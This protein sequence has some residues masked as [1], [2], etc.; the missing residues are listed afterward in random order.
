MLSFVFTSFF[1]FFPLSCATK[2]FSFSL[3]LPI[4]R[5]RFFF[6]FICCLVLYYLRF[7]WC[8]FFRSHLLLFFQFSPFLCLVFFSSFSSS[9]FLPAWSSWFLSLTLVFL[10]S[11]LRSFSSKFF[12]CFQFLL[13]LSSCFFLSY[14][15]RLWGRFLSFLSSVMVALGAAHTNRGLILWLN[16]FSSGTACSRTPRYA[17]AA[18]R[19]KVQSRCCGRYCFFLC[20]RNG[21]TFLKLDFRSDKQ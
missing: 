12:C 4:C 8:F 14:F 19:V 20:P 6:P 18:F 10:H 11:L 17:T 5:V 1:F 2:S 9:F 16:N 3:T 7:T 13:L 15:A 21:D